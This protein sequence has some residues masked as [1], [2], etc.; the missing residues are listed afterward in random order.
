M[1][2]CC[3]FHQKLLCQLIWVLFLLVKVFL[4][5][6]LLIRLSVRCRKVYV[7][8][9]LLPSHSTDRWHRRNWIQSI[10]RDP[11]RPR[12]RFTHKFLAALPKYLNTLIESNTRLFIS[13]CD[14]IESCCLS[15]LGRLGSEAKLVRWTPGR[16][17]LW[18]GVSFSCLGKVT[19]GRKSHAVNS[20]MDLGAPLD[21]WIKPHGSQ[22]H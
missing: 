13:D 6:W 22:G 12:I 8:L 14:R 3:R 5:R 20:G 7:E 17:K 18:Y 9:F 2:T 11:I 16:P 10:L 19:Q 1:L 21:Q 4:S 15:E